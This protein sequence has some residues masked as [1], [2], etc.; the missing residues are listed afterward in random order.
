MF[1]QSHVR[2]NTTSKH[3]S[4]KTASGE[5]RIVGWILLS[6]WHQSFLNMD[7]ILVDIMEILSIFLGIMVFVVM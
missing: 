5:K 3:K 4:T 2:D 1:I 7:C 6:R